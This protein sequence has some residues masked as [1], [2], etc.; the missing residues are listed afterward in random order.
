[1]LRRVKTVISPGWEAALR[2]HSLDTV[3]GV[4]RAAGGKVVARS[5]STEVRE[6]QLDAA[7]GVR[8][9][10]IKKYWARKPS[11]IWSGTFRGTFFGRSKVRREYENLDRLRAW[12]FDA[13]QA[14]SYGEERR[15][16]WLV[17]SYLISEGVPAPIP[18]HVFIRD[19]LSLPNEDSRRM[20]RELIE[21]LAA[22]TRRL[23]DHR[24]VHH[25]Y[26]W[27]NILL[28]GSDLT[29]FFLIDS[30]KGRCW[31]PWGELRSR[32]K[33]LAALQAPA[34][35][36][37]RRTEMMR[38]FL[39]YRNHSRLDRRDKELLRRVLR[40]AAPMREK[41]LQRALRESAAPRTDAV[42]PAPA[43]G[44]IGVQ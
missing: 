9:V 40:L 31:F 10:F 36:F 33:D 26:F 13:P 24:F 14:V 29:R 5:S 8:T 35:R 22:Y 19:R 16:R 23:H 28:T 6:L 4:Y 42:E 21:G 11:Q 15:A 17:R 41:Q 38:F 7:S 43:P 1:M 32:A 3:D 20:R 39:L 2:A 34:P 25:D 12:G 27:R 37:F 30:H 44:K 18:L